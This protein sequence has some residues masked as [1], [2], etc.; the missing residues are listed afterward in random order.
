[1]YRY[2]YDSQTGEILY[3]TMAAG[4]MKYDMP[5]FDHEKNGWNFSN[6]R[7]DLETGKLVETENPNGQGIPRHQL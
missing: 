2:W 7:V 3:R 4:S 6:Y 1:M 5:Y